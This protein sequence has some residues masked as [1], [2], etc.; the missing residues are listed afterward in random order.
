MEDGL[1]QPH[2]NKEL[3]SVSLNPCCNGRWSLTGTIR[4]AYG[5]LGLNPCCNGN[6]RLSQMNKAELVPALSWRRRFSVK[7]VSD[8]CCSLQL[9]LPRG[10]LNPCCN[11]NLRLARWTM[12]SSLEHCHG[13]GDSRWKWSLTDS[14]TSSVML[15]YSLNPCCNGR[16]SLTNKELIVFPR[17][18]GLNP[19][20]N[21]RWSLTW[22]ESTSLMQEM[23]LNPC[24]NGRWSLT[25]W[26][27]R[28]LI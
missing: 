17:G 14:I 22:Q 23:G 18:L 2:W 12:P 16:W 25:I 3:S 11:G 15:T 13:I 9:E 27:C 10:C 20:C 5:T 6:L 8:L 4:Q 26:G 28:V 21:G 7:M 19:C 24:C 1:W